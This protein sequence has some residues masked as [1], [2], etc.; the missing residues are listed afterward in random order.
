[1]LLGVIFNIKES[2]KNQTYFTLKLQ[3]SVFLWFLNNI[4]SWN[5]MRLQGSSEAVM[6]SCIT[7]SFMFCR[8]AEIRA[9]I[10]EPTSSSSLWSLE[11]RVSM[12]QELNS[13]VRG[14]RKQGLQT[15]P[16][17]A[18]LNTSIDQHQLKKNTLFCFLQLHRTPFKTDPN[19]IV[20]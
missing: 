3:F 5:S 9:L 10:I 16:T 14:Q 19:S 4:F 11:Q 18:Q 8:G 6:I 7:S 13:E 12:C 17:A 1:M 2:N 15:A 20:P